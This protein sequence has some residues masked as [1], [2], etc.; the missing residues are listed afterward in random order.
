MKKYILAICLVLLALPAWGATYYVDCNADGDAGAGTGTGAAVAWK[1]IAKVNASSFSA[2]DSILFNKGCT[3]REKLTVPS[4][5]SAGS[6]ITFGAYGSGAKPVISGADINIGAYAAGTCNTTTAA[7]QQTTQTTGLAGNTICQRIDSNIDNICQVN[8]F[9]AGTGTSYVK[10]VANADGTGTQYGGN[11]NTVNHTGSLTTA[12]TWA[13]DYPDI[14]S[15]A[16]LCVVK[17]T[18]DL[19][20]GMNAQP[21]TPIYNGKYYVNGTLQ[22][23]GGANEFLG[24]VD[25]TFKIYGQNT[26]TTAWIAESEDGN[27]NLVSNPEAFNS[28][29]AS[30]LTVTAN[31]HYAPNG[32][33]TADSLRP[34]GTAAPAL[35]YAGGPVTAG[36]SSS[37][38]VYAA[39]LGSHPW[40]YLAFTYFD[41]GWGSLGIE[42]KYFDL[43]MGRP[44]LGTSV[45]VDGF[46]M[47]EAG[48]SEGGTIKWY[49]LSISAAQ[50]VGTANVFVNIYPVSADNSVNSTGDGTDWI[51][52]WGA[53]TEAGEYSTYYEDFTAYYGDCTVAPLVMLENNTPMKRYGSKNMLIDTHE[54]TGSFYFDSDNSRCYVRTSGNNTPAGYTIQ[55][56]V[57]QFGVYA[58][59][60]SFITV[61]GLEFQGQQSLGATE[62]TAGA[63]VGLRIPDTNGTYQGWTI[64]NNTFTRMGNTAINLFTNAADTPGNRTLTGVTID[65]NTFNHANLERQDWLLGMYPAFIRVASKSDDNYWGSVAVSNN[66]I[67]QDVTINPTDNH[68]FETNAIWLELASAAQVSGNSFTDVGHGIVLV[69]KANTV[70]LGSVYNNYGHGGDDQV[71]LNGPYSDVTIHHNILEYSLDASISSAYA[72]SASGNQVNLNVY[73]NVLRTSANACLDIS[74]VTAATIKNNIF[75]TCGTSDAQYLQYSA[76]Y[77]E[78]GASAQVTTTGL[79]SDYNIFYNPTSVNIQVYDSDNA[80]IEY[81]LAHWRTDYSQDTHSSTSD[82]LLTAT[83]ALGAGSPAIDSGVAIVGLHDL[84]N[85]TIT[86]G[87]Y[88]GNTHIYNKHVDMGAIEAGAKRAMP[89]MR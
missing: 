37:F 22:G 6:P 87:D 8:H 36:A 76:I 20:G 3:W 30:N 56:Y 65:G 7:L 31:T 23:L 42:G 50:P 26:A 67:T 10:F 25:M 80:G 9:S 13:A 45:G 1:T 54:G 35:V 51:A 34:T 88:S 49:W 78:D 55:N 66:T 18:G 40:V 21:T 63:G 77:V 28:W 2:G 38:S 71:W 83:Y 68:I 16:Y 73:N 5:G 24:Y 17:A 69:G 11:S 43:T 75:D 61:D 44:A 82:P 46:S 52:V 84:P 27:D 85:R 62:T 58:S 41:A 79:T 15:G 53:K 33:L 29:T 86:G 72:G 32:T 4:S 14:S 70:D 12:Y 60:K 64:Q 57:R 89:R 81:T 59:G 74:L 19:T 47:T 39:A 48:T